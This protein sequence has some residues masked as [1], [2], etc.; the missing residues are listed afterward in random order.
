MLSYLHGNL[1]DLR[2]ETL[3]DYLAKNREQHPVEP[4]LNP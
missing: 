2:E 3:A 4:D 1:D